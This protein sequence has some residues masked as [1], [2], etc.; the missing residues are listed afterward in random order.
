M[1]GGSRSRAFA[2]CLLAAGLLS[3]CGEDGSTAAPTPA[4]T[5]SGESPVVA[6]GQAGV[7]PFVEPTCPTPRTP[8]VAPGLTR[9]VEQITKLGEKRYGGGY[10]GAIPCVPAG[11]VVVYRVPSAGTDFMR[12]VTRIARAQNVEATFADARFSYKQ[13]QATRKAVLE[14]F[15][16]LDEAGAPFAVLRVHENGTVEVAVRANVAAAE[17][18][19]SDLLDRIYVVL[20]PEETASP[21][22]ES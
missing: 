16:R 12:A 10:A 4:P 13:A 21:S 5:L 1:A 18:V 14:Q 2:G 20:I 11:R 17:Q 15:A 19:L 3:G 9:A 22:P 8:K 7:K 6:T